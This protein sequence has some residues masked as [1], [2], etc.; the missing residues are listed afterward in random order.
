MDTLSSGMTFCQPVLHARRPGRD[1]FPPPWY[2]P[3]MTQERHRRSKLRRLL[4]FPRFLPREAAAAASP[5]EGELL[6]ELTGKNP[7]NLLFGRFDARWLR[8]HLEQSGI[9]AGL[10]RKGYPDPL[11]TL[12]CTD[13]GDQR[14][15]LHDKTESWDRLLLEARLQLADFRPKTPIGPFTE[16]DSFRMLIIHWLVLSDPDR[17]FSFRRPRLPG[18]DRPGLGLLTESLRL[19]RGIGKELLIDGVLD[20]PDHFHTALVYAGAM[21]FFDPEAEGLFRAMARD[22]AAVPLAI[23]SEAVREGAMVDAGSG[24]PLPWLPAEQILPIHGPLRRY[25]RSGGYRER[26]DAVFRRTRVAIEW[27]LYRRKIAAAGNPGNYS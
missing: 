22:L 5:S 23:A 12:S 18:Q 4:A 20:L 1:A 21:H 2:N 24:E 10:A 6:F 17:P 15:Y 27:D 19:L 9:L 14:I 11:L 7:G 26:S 13:P 25:F 16:E 8:D 3:R